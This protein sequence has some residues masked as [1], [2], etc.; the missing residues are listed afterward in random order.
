MRVRSLFVSVA[1]M[2]LLAVAVMAAE[3]EINLEGVKCVMKPD[4]PAKAANAVDYKGGKVFF[5]CAGCVGKFDPKNEK[6]AT[7]ANH[8]LVVTKQAKQAN[9]PLSGGPCKTEFTTKV[10]GV[11]V[12]F[13][14]SNCQGKVAKTEG[15]AQIAMVFGDKAFE[16]AYK[17][18][19]KK[20]GEKKAE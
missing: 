13:C 14:C 17:V 7:M 5:C 6:A 1:A 20:E 8:Q 9:C 12:Y 3:K 2:G 18:G 4:A 16:K 11:D 19:E 10:G 15:E